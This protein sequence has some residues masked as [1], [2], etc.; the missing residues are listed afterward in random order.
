MH[1][2]AEKDLTEK[3]LQE[4]EDVREAMVKRE[5]KEIRYVMDNSEGEK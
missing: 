2:E 5:R 4:S 3:T 1:K